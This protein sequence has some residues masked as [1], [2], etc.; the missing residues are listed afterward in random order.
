M[1]L[2]LT[3]T[4]RLY[5]RDFIVR[6]TLIASGA[7]VIAGIIIPIL[8]FPRGNNVVLHYNVS[9]G[10]DLVGSWFKILLVPFIMLLLLILNFSVGLWVWRRDRVLS[11]LL[12]SGTIYFITILLLALS[13]LT[14]VSRIYAY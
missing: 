7:C 13:L 2:Y 3:P 14:F 8:W 1:K 12:L 9:F 5:F 11:Y 4:I 10:I 6:S